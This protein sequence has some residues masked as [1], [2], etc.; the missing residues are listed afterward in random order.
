MPHPRLFLDNGGNTQFLLKE[1]GKSLTFRVRIEPDA[2]YPQGVTEWHALDEIRNISTP[3]QMLWSLIYRK[4]K[5][6]R[7]CTMITPYEEDALCE[8]I[9][10]QNNH[11]AL[12]CKGRILDLNLASRE[13]V[14]HS[15]SSSD[16]AYMGAAEEFSMLPRIM[17]KNA[18]GQSFEVHLQSHIIGN[19]G[20]SGDLLSRILLGKAKPEWLGNEVS[21][22]VGMQRIDLMVS[23]SKGGNGM[24]HVMPIEL[25]SVKASADNLRQIQRYVDW[26]QQYYI[27]NCR[28]VISPV[29]I[30]KAGGM[31]PSDFAERVRRF[32]NENAGDICEPLR[33]VEFSV[34]SGGISYEERDFC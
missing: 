10:K 7:G 33:M 11:K 25:K 12:S 23:Y 18:R 27:P 28:S 1:L 2:V 30:T 4:L 32:N 31:L 5:G 22:G 8:L 13:I 9:R 6:N 24:R 19:F 16:F 15:D 17:E 29:L 14:V 21:C 3:Y 20:N 26:I 34:G